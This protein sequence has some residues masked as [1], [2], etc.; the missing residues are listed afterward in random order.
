MFN[1]LCPADRSSQV[2]GFGFSLKF[3][4]LSKTQELVLENK[5]KTKRLLLLKSL[6]VR[7]VNK[8]QIYKHITTKIIW[9][10]KLFIDT[11][12]YKHKIYATA[13]RFMLQNLL[14]LH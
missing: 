12:K 5:G 3:C 13:V 2:L 1:L 6:V 10:I 14:L 7:L 9:E 11:Q 8:L 4:K